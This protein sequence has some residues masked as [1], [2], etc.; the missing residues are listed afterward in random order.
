MRNLRG[1]SPKSR[2]HNVYHLNVV[3]D[4]RRGKGGGG[5][6]GGEWGFRVIMVIII[7]LLFLQSC[8]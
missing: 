8:R 6:S 1:G 3:R 5:G 2:N 7:V 4:G